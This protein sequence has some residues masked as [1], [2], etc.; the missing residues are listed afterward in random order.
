MEASSAGP[1]QIRQTMSVCGKHTLALEQP[2]EIQVIGAQP[3][4][5]IY[6]MGDLPM[7]IGIRC[8]SCGTAWPTIDALRAG[9]PGSADEVEP[10]EG[11]DES[12]MRRDPMSR[13]GSSSRRV[14]TTVAAIG[15]GVVLAVT[16]LLELGFIAVGAAVLA[17]RA[18]AG[19]RRQT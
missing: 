18:L 5:E 1:E 10:V 4:T 2:P 13:D 15:T 9:E 7:P 12:D 17:M 11:L 6:R 19:R 8:R 16:G 3:Y 14:V